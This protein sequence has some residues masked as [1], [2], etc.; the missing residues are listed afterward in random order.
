MFRRGR[1]GGGGG[2][3]GGGGGGGGG[4]DGRASFAAAVRAGDV[5]TVKAALAADSTLGRGPVDGEETPLHEASE[6]GYTDI[7]EE[8]LRVGATVDAVDKDGWSPLHWAAKSGHKDVAEKLLRAS[9]AVDA[10]DKY[11]STPLHQAACSGHKDVA[12]QLLLS[13]AAVDAADADGSTP[14][15]LAAGSGHKDV[16]EQ[17]LHAGAAV[18]AV[19]LLGWTPLHRAAGAGHKDVAE[20]LLVAGAAVDARDVS[21]RTPLHRAAEAVLR[22]AFGDDGIARSV[23]VVCVLVA[24]GAVASADVRPSAVRGATTRGKR[25]R[26]ALSTTRVLSPEEISDAKAEWNAAAAKAKDEVAVVSAAARALAELQVVHDGFVAAPETLTLAAIKEEL[27]RSRIR[28][29]RCLQIAHRVLLFAD[30]VGVFA[31]EDG[32]V[33]TQRRHDLFQRVYQPTV[34]WLDT[35]GDR[36][37][38]ASIV[39]HAAEQGLVDHVHLSIMGVALELDHKFS[40]QLKAVVERLNRLESATVN[41]GK[42]LCDTVQELRDLKEHLRDKEEL[43]RKVALA[44]SAVKIGVSLAPVVGAALNASVDVVAA[45]ADG[46]TELAVVCRHLVDPADIAAARQVM[47][48]VSDASGTLPAAQ[49]EQ[50]QAVLHPYT[51]IK[52]VNEALAFVEEALVDE[53]VEDEGVSG[54]IPKVQLDSVAEEPASDEAEDKLEKF[55]DVVIDVAIEHGV[56]EMAPDKRG[57]A[58][59]GS[60]KS[61]PTPV[62]TP[63]GVQGGAGV[64]APPYNSIGR[65]PPA[66]PEAAESDEAGTSAAPLPTPHPVRPPSSPALAGGVAASVSPPPAGPLAHA[67]G[68]LVGATGVPAMALLRGGGPSSPATD[69]GAPFFAGVLRW[70]CDTLAS[71]L[72]DYVTCGYAPP[73]RAAFDT[74]V[75]GCAA[76]H[77]IVGATLV[78]CRDPAKTAAYLLGE[79]PPSHGVAVSVTSFIEDAQRYAASP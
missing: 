59:P 33:T 77:D 15:H 4:D 14:L 3:G 74:L 69:F 57:R 49:L 45:F 16:A 52:D 51:S 37:L 19:D 39:H 63:A 12:E 47:Q 22:V 41:A 1:R 76:A 20:Q 23:E 31:R 44:K 79:S 72:V 62:A 24:W 68:E 67:P 5:A 8:L 6:L 46:T 60:A 42:L 75:R 9:A 13:G 34:G 71:K 28:D 56:D 54:D 11:A 55:K 2:S 26:S 27:V 21:G 10:A 38:V 43:D 17:L 25:L 7:A 32:G 61:T 66:R 64:H 36:G 18:D 48:H 53:G 73:K 65:S 35:P 50:L 70:D 78:R 58:Q 30:R 40:T 29:A